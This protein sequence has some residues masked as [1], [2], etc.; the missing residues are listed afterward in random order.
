MHDELAAAG[1]SRL[2]RSARKAQEHGFFARIALAKKG[3]KKY[4]GY[5]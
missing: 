2:Q 5:A 3:Q 1:N 4:W